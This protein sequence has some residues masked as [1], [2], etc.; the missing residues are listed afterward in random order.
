M[1]DE[2]WIIIL[3]LNSS[4]SQWHGAIQHPQGRWNSRVCCQLAKSWAH[5]SG[6]GSCSFELLASAYRDNS[7]VWPQYWNTKTLECLPSLSL[8]YKKNVLSAAPPWQHYRVATSTLQF[9]PCTTR[10]LFISSFKKK[11]CK[12]TSTP[13]TM[14]HRVSFTSGCRGW[15]TTFTRQEYIV[16]YR[17]G[18]RLF[19]NVESTL[20]NSYASSNDV[21]KVCK[22]FHIL[23]L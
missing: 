11:N 10:L 7:E 13:V 1:G 8:S 14:C 6:W 22:N 21:V 15:R 12:G 20:Q 16:L 17:G 9:W 5:S 23:N 18:R 19:A 3:N 2:T 4:G